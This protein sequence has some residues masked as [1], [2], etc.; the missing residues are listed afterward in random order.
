MD[1]RWGPGRA[2]SDDWAGPFPAGINC[3]NESRDKDPPVKGTE[4]SATALGQRAAKFCVI[5]S[6]SLVQGWLGPVDWFNYSLYRP[7][8]CLK[9][10][11]NPSSTVTTETSSQPSAP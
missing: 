4:M 3:F 6:Q 10:K 7:S 11:R 9:K 1:A 5:L 2:T 8:G